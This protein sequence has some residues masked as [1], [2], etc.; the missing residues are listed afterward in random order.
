MHK[1]TTGL[2]L[3]DNLLRPRSTKKYDLQKI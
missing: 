3:F 1:G 2:Q